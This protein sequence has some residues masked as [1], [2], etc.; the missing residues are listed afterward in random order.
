MNNPIR[1]VLTVFSVGMA[2]ALIYAIQITKKAGAVP[3]EGG[4]PIKY[5]VSETALESVYD[6]AF[7]SPALNA[8]W[9]W[10]RGDAN[11]WSLSSN[12]G[13]MTITT[14]RTDIWQTNN[15]AALLM[16][17]IQTADQDAYVLQTSIQMTPAANFHQAGLLIYQDDNNYVRLSFAWISGISFELG[18]EVNGSFSSVIADGPAGASQVF[19]QLMKSGNDYTAYYSLNAI[20]WNYIGA[21]TGVDIAPTKFGL[22]AFNGKRTTPILIPAKFDYFKVNPYEDHFESADLQPQWSWVRGDP[23]Q[24]SLTGNPHHLT[25]TTR[26]QDIWQH[27]NDAALLLQDILASGQDTFTV[28]TSV[29][30][31]P[32]ENFQ[33][34]GIVIYQ[35][36]NNYVRLSFGWMGGL[37]FEF[38]RE[39]NGA[40]S[41]VL[42][43]AP[44]GS[45]SAFLRIHKSGADYSAACSQNGTDW[46]LIGSHA[47]VNIAPE[48]FGLYAFNAKD[49]STVG[50]PAV[51]DYFS[52]LTYSDP[53]APAP[54]PTPTPVNTP[55]PT[56][57]PT[58]TDT[59]TPSPTDPFYFGSDSGNYWN[60]PNGTTYNPEEFQNFYIGRIGR[61]TYGFDTANCDTYTAECYWALGLTVITVP[62][63]LNIY[64]YA[65]WLLTGPAANHTGTEQAN[66]FWDTY[67][68]ATGINYEGLPYSH[69]LHGNTLFVDIE[70]RET[71]WT[72]DI[73]ANRQIV[74]AFLLEL[75][76][77]IMANPDSNIDHIGVYYSGDWSTIM[78]T[79]YQFPFEVVLWVADYG[80][81]DGG[82]CQMKTLGGQVSEDVSPLYVSRSDVANRILDFFN[83]YGMENIRALQPNAQY[84]PAIWQFC[85]DYGVV[86]LQDP[87]DFHPQTG[88]WVLP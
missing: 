78:G 76:S 23:T 6:D 26:P 68:G 19:L 51:F 46:V 21:R 59:P 41:S 66:A 28:E 65:Y 30:F 74:A 54:T 29:Q 73:D 17:N 50:I 60:N 82:H 1:K 33:Q 12:P 15:D 80:I 42:L 85:G 49:V 11:I 70:T 84:Y 22:Y 13:F 16:Q 87:G 62:D 36:D 38:G 4:N 86:T 48:K 57:A 24:W 64:K 83:L 25:I 45:S 55:M 52:A 63:D 2:T 14:R 77:I 79:G 34:A 56:D 72:S 43:A 58:P 67:T 40:F 10:I 37:K 71:T 27:N 35:N 53:P 31:S 8:K 88:P 32:T 39:E 81:A 18:R 20:D 61:G 69:Y 9:S 7:D 75:K 5:S 47:A 44:E 3:P